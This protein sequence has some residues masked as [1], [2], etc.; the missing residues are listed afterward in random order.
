M[1]SS[2]AKVIDSVKWY[3]LPDDS[4]QNEEDVTFNTLGFTGTGGTFILYL[5]SA[6]AGSKRYMIY[7]KN[8]SGNLT[9]TTGIEGKSNITIPSGSSIADI[10]VDTEGNILKA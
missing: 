5:N 10:Y 7:A 2:K 1:A 9:L 6:K 4:S 8:L 3:T